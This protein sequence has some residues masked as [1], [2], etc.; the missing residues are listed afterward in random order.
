MMTI[1]R[2]LDMT[3]IAAPLLFVGLG[4]PLVAQS[5]E[6]QTP[7]QLVKAMIANEREASNDHERYEYLSNERSDRTCGHLWTERVVETY[8]GRVRLLLSEDGKPLSAD[9]AQRE[10]ARLAHIEDHPEEFIHHE[11]GVRNEEKRAREMLDALPQDFTFDNVRLKEGVWYM[12]FHPNP[13]YSPSGLEERILHGMAGRIAIDAHAMRLIHLEFHLTQEVNIGFGLL[14]SVHTGTTFIS[15]R[16]IVD[17]RWHT[18]H[19]ATQV[20]GKAVL[21]KRIDYNLDLKRADFQV[22]DQ[23][24]TVPQAAALLLR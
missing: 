22:L 18:L 19:V 16:Q 20:H 8:A 3:T 6:P 13:Q 9:R 21:F 14:A 4:I 11:Q 2:M 5:S 10:H 12:D 17:G 15:D 24:I 1:R 7:L 23:N